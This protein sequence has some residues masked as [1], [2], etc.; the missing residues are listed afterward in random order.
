MGERERASVVVVNDDPIQLR[1]IS[2]ILEKDGWNV[3]ACEG[4]ELALKIID[5]QG[6]PDVIITDLHMPGIDGWRFC[7]LLRSPEYPQ[8]NQIPILVISATFS[9]T[10]THQVTID[11]GANA[12]LEAP[13]KASVLKNYVKSLLAGKSPAFK[14]RVLIVESDSEQMR[15]LIRSFENNGYIVDVAGSL[16]E[17]RNHFK[18]NLPN[19]A[20]INYNLPDG[21]GDDLLKDIKNPDSMVIAIL[22]TE[23]PSP[24]LALKFIREG[25]DAYVHKPFEPEYLID[26]C[27]KAYR[28]RSLLR[29]ED[30][31]EDRTR[32]L[33]ES[34]S[35]FRSLFENCRDAI[36][37]STK[38]GEI[39][40]VNQ[41]ALNLFG[42]TKEEMLRLNVKDLLYTCPD[43]K[44][45]DRRNTSEER[46]AESYYEDKLRKKDGSVIDCLISSSPCYN[47][48]GTVIGYQGIIRDITLRKKMQSELLKIQKLESIGIL[49]GGIAH[50]F[51]NIL[52]AVLGNLSLAKIYAKSDERILEKLVEA[53]KASLRAKGLTQQLLT[54]SKG[55]EPVKK[56]VSLKGLL[57]D[58]SKFA[59]IDHNVS[60][61]LTIPHDTWLVNIDEAQMGQVF[62]NIITN[63]DQA[64]PAGGIIDINVENVN[65]EGDELTQIESGKY[66]KIT[67]KDH[68][69]G[70]SKEDL[71]KIFDPY[72]TTK[73]EG[74][75]LGLSSAYSIVKNHGGYIT[76]ESEPGRGSVFHVFLPAVEIEESRRETRMLVPE[77]GAGKILIM[78]DEEIVR[79]IVEN[80]L[81]YIGY[82][83]VTANDGIEA[84][85]R[86]REAKEL[87]EPFDAII[88]DLTIP[89]GVGG[90]EAIKKIREFDPDV[91]SI[92][93]SGYSN[94]PIMSHYEEYG[95]KGV[96]SKPYRI[97]E[98]SEVL[99]RVI[100][101]DPE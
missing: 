100:S 78:D 97:E 2:A 85:E 92:V 46:K 57:T 24:G 79:D 49:A 12:F 5:E 1:T 67:F 75:G 98:L 65:I 88:M 40:D 71:H 29:I 11:L 84:I 48:D 43:G 20:V 28:E 62:N 55:G 90:K 33:S 23:D 32:K 91:K 14:K 59:P 86:Y 25:A 42:Y 64:M 93:S 15:R 35:K 36:Y 51:N 18:R 74:C 101:G 27:E 26:L 22:T 70:I 77:R 53:E 6:P 68:G 31:L 8:L 72:Y 41:A 17:G 54:F 60:C 96:I 13:F 38:D 50:D 94:D 19:V 39:I 87:G 83:V 81:K 10:D 16:D 63:A 4:A 76:V 73:Q 58:S 3:I 7:R 66:V 80:M 69:V 45:Q 95:F 99:Y 34:E 82:R 89:G 47:Y 61:K 21:K 9:G 52:T 56:V 30:I 37:I 44:S